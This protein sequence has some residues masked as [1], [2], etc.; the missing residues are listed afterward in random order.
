MGKLQIVCSRYA[1]QTGARHLPRLVVFSFRRHPSVQKMEKNILPNIL[2]PLVWLALAWFA[3]FLFAYD[4]APA[5]YRVRKGDTLY[6]LARRY[7]VSVQELMWANGLQGSADLRLDM[8]LKIPQKDVEQNGP[9]GRLDE[10]KAPEEAKQGYGLHTVVKGDTYYSIAKRYAI[11][12]QDLLS[13]NNLNTA[14]TLRLGQVLTVRFASAHNRVQEGRVPE[15]KVQRAQNDDWERPDADSADRERDNLGEL[16]REESYFWP[17]SGSREVLGGELQGVRISALDESLVYAVQSG[18]IIWQGPYRN[19]GPV[20]LLASADG[21]VYLYG[22]NVHFLVNIGQEIL[23]GDPLGKVDTQAATLV[24]V[25]GA[26]DY[27]QVYFSVFYKNTFVP[28]EAAP[29]G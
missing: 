17:V 1:R 4:N 21:H 9:H 18:R 3:P 15:G 7:G 25:L 22:G 10:R 29:R 6:S 12:L 8:L 27:G 16:G 28:A 14:A 19:Y 2:G 20:A 23:A 26:K 11:K 24:D 13:L 5:S